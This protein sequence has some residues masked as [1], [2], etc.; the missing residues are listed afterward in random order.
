[1][2]GA[3]LAV[4]DLAQAV[5]LHRGLL[6]NGWGRW[7]RV[8]ADTVDAA[9]VA[10]LAPE[11]GPAGCGALVPTASFAGEAAYLRG[12]LQVVATVTPASI[13]VGAV[14]A[15]RGRP[16][17]V[18][19]LVLWPAVGAAAGKLL[20]VTEA[21][22]IRRRERM[23]LDRRRAAGQEG[24]LTG[25]RQWVRSNGRL[26]DRLA[27]FG[28]RIADVPGVNLDS[29]RMLYARAADQKDVDP[30]QP[31]FPTLLEALLR[32]YEIDRART[33]VIAHRLVVEE[34]AEDDGEL[35]LDGYQSQRLWDTLDQLGVCGHLRVAVVGLVKRG[36]GTD[37]AVT[38]SSSR[39]MINDNPV[40]EELE[41]PT[42]AKSWRVELV[43]LG[44]LLAGIY[45]LSACGPGGCQVHW[46]AGAGCLTASCASAAAAEWR[47]RR[48]GSDAA[49]GAALVGLGPSLLM[50][51]WGSRRMRHT[52][53]PQGLSYYPG[54]G[55]LTGISFILAFYISTMTTRERV[56]LVAGLIVQ[57]GTSW[58]SS[59][60]P[61]DRLVFWSELIWTAGAMV[62]SAGLATT[63]RKASD[64]I[65]DELA[66]GTR[67]Y[68]M[69][70]RLA[71]WASQQ[72][73]ARALHELAHSY[74]EQAKPHDE[75]ER[76]TIAK[77]REEHRQLGIAL[78]NA[79]DY[80][81]ATPN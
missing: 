49:P 47:V 19:D 34:L 24:L 32:Q 21:Q 14:R 46:S 64:S 79:Q 56:M 68:A 50:A 67:A 26:L 44:L 48:R 55:A 20:A 28:A 73:A 57:L 58:L 62:G 8:A 3:A 15:I 1:M 39:S 4:N 41:L 13:A 45:Q 60:E 5:M 80:R 25:R 33:H 43:T 72:R 16:V 53:S 12:P 63:A 35:L 66:D 11:D 69:D 36:L 7:L 81:S 77:A 76:T 74:L 6:D 70:Q 42:G 29:A 9:L 54:L 2:V 38:I 71:G 40:T 37:I 17:L 18:G 22:Q 65:A 51:V 10:A 52:H 75:E 78:R 30:P 61:R 59:P 31:G 23:E 27:R